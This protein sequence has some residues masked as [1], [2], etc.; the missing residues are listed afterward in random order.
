M[1]SGAGAGA[2][3]AAGCK[4]FVV[5]G[6]AVKRQEQRC[7]TRVTYPVLLMPK[8]ADATKPYDAKTVSISPKVL[9]CPTKPVKARD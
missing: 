7:P 1:G 3:I 5:D 4:K 6:V 9:K 8:D 2:M